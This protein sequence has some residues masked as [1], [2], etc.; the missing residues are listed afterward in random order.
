M[1]DIHTHILPF[2]DDGAKDMETSLRMIEESA[3]IGVTD[4]FLTPHFMKSRNYLSLASENQMI[5]EKLQAAVKAKKISI[6]LHL[7]NEVF[8]TI[9]SI[10]DIREGLILPLGNSKLILIEFSLG[11]DHEAIDEAIHNMTSMGYT[12]V[13]AHPERYDY[14][15]FKRDFSVIKKMGA[16]IQVN[17]SAVIGKAGHEQHKT[18]L[19]LIKKGYADFVASDIHASRQN[20]MREAYDFISHKF[21]KDKAERLCNNKMAL[22][23]TTK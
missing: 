11:D 21:G 3:A 7:G 19:K 10:R 20:Y 18:V 15:E 1:I 16:L 5:F 4:L 12:P 6:E 2:I 9:D 17:A 23:D 22:G 13:I 8:Y 14:L